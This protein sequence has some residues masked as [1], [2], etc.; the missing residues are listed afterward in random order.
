MAEVTVNGNNAG[1]L[2]TS[3][4]RTDISGL[5]KKGVNVIEIRIT[6]QWTNR[7]IGDQKAPAANKVLNSQVMVWGRN[8][9]E[10]GLLGPVTI[11]KST[12]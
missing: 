8:P 3:P 12:E 4:F 1:L 11:L 10:S 7:L 5:L 2:W 9:V 6:N